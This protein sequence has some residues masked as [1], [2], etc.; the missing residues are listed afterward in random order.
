MNRCLIVFILWA[1]LVL[2]GTAMSDDAISSQMRLETVPELP[3]DDTSLIGLYVHNFSTAKLGPGVIPPNDIRRLIERLPPSPI[4][5]LDRDIL[6]YGELPAVADDAGWD[7]IAATTARHHCALALGSVGILGVIQSNTSLR[8]PKPKALAATYENVLRLK[9]AVSESAAHLTIKTARSTPF[10]I[11]NLIGIVTAGYDILV[12][13][14]PLLPV[15]VD[16]AKFSKR[17]SPDAAAT[18]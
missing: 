2:P 14:D 7:A 17:V 15:L 13:N 3:S 16:S 18:E 11:I 4:D 8:N 5:V 12:G 6:C 10:A 9:P 1:M